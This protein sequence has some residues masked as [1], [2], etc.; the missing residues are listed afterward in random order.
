MDKTYNICKEFAIKSSN[1]EW[2]QYHECLAKDLRNQ[3]MKTLSMQKYGK[4]INMFC[5]IVSKQTL[6]FLCIA[7]P[8]RYRNPLLTCL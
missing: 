7:V 5:N 8:N 4:Q 6:Y 1:S 2:N 3:F